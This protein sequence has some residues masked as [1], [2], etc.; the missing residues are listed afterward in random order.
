[1]SSQTF[2]SYRSQPAEMM[3]D[4]IRLAIGSHWHKVSMRVVRCHL[5]FGLESVDGT[6][7]YLLLRQLVQC[8]PDSSCLGS[9]L[10]RLTNVTTYSVHMYGSWDQNLVSGWLGMFRIESSKYGTG[11]AQDLTALA[12]FSSIPPPAAPMPVF[13]TAPSSEAPGNIQDQQP[14]TEQP[15]GDSPEGTF[16]E[17]LARDPAAQ[18][19]AESSPWVFLHVVWHSIAPQE[20]LYGR[21]CM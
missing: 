12:P 3:L 6:H 16:T 1:M 11:G 17:L 9:T 14:Q 20:E 2:V 21:L 4:E 13:K 19:P 5:V 7:S 15:A 18:T 10:P 8:F